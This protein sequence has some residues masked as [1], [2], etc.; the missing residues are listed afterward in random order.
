MMKR[1]LILGLAW[2]LCSY[3]FGNAFAAGP[4]EL[5]TRNVLLVT[6]DGLRWQEVFRGAEE[7]LVSKEA[8]NVKEVP[9]T[10]DA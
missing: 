7:R 5:H 2:C 8:G 3:S 4:E 9:A 1:W 6:I 10:R